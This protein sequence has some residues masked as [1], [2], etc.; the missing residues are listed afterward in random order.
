MNN[1][2]ELLITNKSGLN[3][4]LDQFDDAV[5][6]L[7]SDDEV[8]SSSKESAEISGWSY[9]LDLVL[10]IV[11]VFGIAWFIRMMIVSPF[12]VDG[13][14][15]VPSLANGDFLIVNK[16]SYRLDEPERGDIIIFRPPDQENVFYVKRVIGLPGETLE[17]TNGQIKIRNNIYPDGINLPEKYLNEENNGHTYLPSR[18]NQKVYIPEEHYF[19]M[20]DNRNHSSDSRAWLSA[21]PDIGGTVSK[22]MIVGRADL[23]IWIPEKIFWKIGLPNAEIIPNAKY[24]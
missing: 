4:K 6:I 3:N 16:L 8:I 22:K 17:F 24:S 12:Y 1:S 18:A 20:G 7:N 5:E 9:I 2:D 11:I 14:S 21:H 15:M 23:R 19:L 13:Q 10:N